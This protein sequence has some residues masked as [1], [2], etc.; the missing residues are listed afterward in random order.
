VA[1]VVLAVVLLVIAV[2]SLV[3]RDGRH[4]PLADI[5]RDVSASRCVSSDSP[6]LLVLSSALRS[7]LEHGCPVVLDPTGTRY[8]TDR[9]HL[10]NGPPGPSSRAATGYQRA[11]V[12]WYG[13]SDA[14]M[15]T[16]IRGGLSD[17]SI[18]EIKRR[19]PVETRRGS[20]TI[21]LPGP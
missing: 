17:A 5:A 15:F 6:A 21:R 9:G 2:P 13:G 7:D 19:L 18:A 11:M 16:R 12:A 1:G 20:V 10:L 4:L 3:R 8:D 14:T